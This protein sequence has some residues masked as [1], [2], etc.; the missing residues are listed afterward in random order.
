M[1]SNFS[2]TLPVLLPLL[3]FLSAFFSGSESALFSLNKTDLYK[4]ST[5]KRKQ[6]IIFSLMK[7]PQ[8]ILVTLLLYN[9]L[10]NTLI[11]TVTTDL[12]TT[13][14]PKYGQFLTIAVATPFIILF[15]EISPKVLAINFNV[16]VSTLVSSIIY[17]FHKIIAPF[18]IIILFITNIIIRFFKLE[19]SENN[20]ITEGEL[21]AAVELGENTGAITQEESAFIKNILRLSQKS[22]QSIMIPRNKMIAVEIGTPIDEVISL[23]LDNPIIRMPVYENDLDNIIGTIDSR[24]LLDYYHNYKKAKVITRK[25]LIP[26]HFFPSTRE[27]SSLLNDFIEK[28]MQ[29]GILLDEYGGT[30]GMVTLSG[31]ITEVMG[32]SFSLSA[33][34][35]KTDVRHID[36]ITVIS[37]DMLIVDFNEEFDD[38][39]QTS[40]SETVAGYII[41]VLERLPLKSDFIYTEKYILKVRRLSKNTIES[42]E[43]VG[44]NVIDI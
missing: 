32:E 34:H 38:N 10:V 16:Q 13:F 39:L 12:F 19:I 36:N 20:K 24:M 25:M 31:I 9:L 1:I 3:L 33:E 26:T 7:N 44:R 43:V 11:S 2:I 21:D 40:E 8:Q 6:K 4:M 5:G 35:Q 29:L 15:G 41:E 14:F 18:R 30:M 22:A 42:I 17:F 28:K 23:F 37:G 27:L